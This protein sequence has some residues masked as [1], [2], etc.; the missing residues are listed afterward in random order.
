MNSMKKSLGCLAMIFFIAT[1]YG[2]AG[3]NPPENGSGLRFEMSF[4]ESAHDQSVTGRMF[5]VVSNTSSSEPR[6]QIRR[7]GAVVYVNRNRFDLQDGNVVWNGRKVG[8]YD[9]QG[10]GEINKKPIRI[11][12]PKQSNCFLLAEVRS[13][14]V[15]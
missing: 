4:P 7:T 9:R 10:C 13:Q 15:A 8:W 12:R 3:I 14:N 5:V 1:G 6:L 11:Y 2:F